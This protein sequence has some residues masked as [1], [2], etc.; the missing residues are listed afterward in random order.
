MTD[1]DWGPGARLESR[2]FQM[3]RCLNCGAP[4]TGVTGPEGDPDPGC[5]MVC[6]YCSHVMEWDG[7]KLAP[8]SDEAIDDI[9]G[10]PDVRDVV[11]L[12]G[13]YRQEVGP[14]AFCAACG[15]EN[16]VGVIRCKRCGK[17]LVFGAGGPK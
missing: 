8:L 2:K 3:G 4:L 13:L 16:T 1:R 9:A 14:F 10:D 7:A 11:E 15:A 12:T 6:A 5:V 17:P